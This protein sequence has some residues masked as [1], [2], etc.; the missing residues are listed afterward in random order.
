[1]TRKLFLLAA[2]FAT[3]NVFAAP[4][5]A[6]IDGFK[7][8]YDEAGHQILQITS[9]VRELEGTPAALTSRAQLCAPRSFSTSSTTQ[10][11]VL[12]ALGGGFAATKKEPVPVIEFSDK[13]S[14][15]LIANSVA[16]YTAALLTYLARSKITFEA[17]EGRFRVI[18]TD[19]ATAR[20]DGKADYLPLVAVWGTGW[21]KATKALNTKVEAFI[22]CIASPPSESDW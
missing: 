14:G 15:Q 8:T 18:Q 12:E 6:E 21:E 4:P 20:A 2:T 13:E 1:M 11:S 9:A 19:M 17:K 10:A 22:S 3:H 16:P 7:L 5:P